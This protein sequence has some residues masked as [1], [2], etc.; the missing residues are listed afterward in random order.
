MHV[1]F[2]FYGKRSDYVSVPLHYNHLVQSMIYSNISREL[3]D[4][5]HNRGFVYGGR[6]FKLFTF[7]RILGKA[8]ISD[9]RIVFEGGVML[10]VGS[11]IE[12]FIKELA[13]SL[14]R[15]GEIVLGD[16]VLLV[17]SVR[18][19]K[20]PEF[21]EETV[22]RT[23]SPVTIYST[24]Y[25]PAGRKKTYYYSPKEREFASLICMNAQKKHKILRGEEDERG[26]EIEAIRA[27]EAVVFYRGTVVKAWSGKFVL[28]GSSSLMRTVY[29]AGLGGKNSQGFGMFE[30]VE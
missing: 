14:L 20:Y 10:Y 19:P 9:G 27:R 6:A 23:L 2:E 5:L 28:R 21:G 11:P 30:V 18:F 15:C 26:L 17:S 1:C 4:F 25:T 7:S 12:R 8:R 3:A 24:L 13:T 29:E 22:I 16:D